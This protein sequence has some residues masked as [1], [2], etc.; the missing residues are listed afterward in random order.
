[1][2]KLEWLAGSDSVTR[3]VSFIGAK[4]SGVDARCIT[5]ADANYNDA[6]KMDMQRN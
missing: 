4:D 2:H 5:I 3:V 1:M 6:L